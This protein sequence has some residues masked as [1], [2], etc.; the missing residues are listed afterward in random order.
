MY[1]IDFDSPKRDKFTSNKVQKGLFISES[2]IF[3]YDTFEV[4]QKPQLQKPI[5]LK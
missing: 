4:Q 5:K 1:D 2:E 3:E